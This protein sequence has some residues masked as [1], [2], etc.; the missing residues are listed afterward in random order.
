MLKHKRLYSILVSVGMLI[1]A[2][3]LVYLF[4][5]IYGVSKEN[6]TNIA[7]LEIE[8]NT[9]DLDYI[10]QQ[11]VFEVNMTADMIDNMIKD[12]KSND[13]IEKSLQNESKMTIAAFGKNSSGKDIVNGLYGYIRDKFQDGAG[14]VPDSNFKPTERPW[15]KEAINGNGDAVFVDPYLDEY[16][17][18]ETYIMTISKMLSDNKSVV[19]LD[20]YLTKVEEQVQAIK[21]DKKLDNLV[22]TDSGFVVSSTETEIVGKNIAKTNNLFYNELSKELSIAN[23]KDFEFRYDGT[24]YTVFNKGLYDGWT[25]LVIQET[26]DL[27]S[28]LKYLYI[29]F[30]SIFIVIVLGT[31]LLVYSI[32]RKR[33]R[34]EDINGKLNS[35]A[36]VYISMFKFDFVNKNCERVKEDLYFKDINVK[37]KTPEELFF[38]IKTRLLKNNKNELSTIDLVKEINDIDSTDVHTSEYETNLGWIRERFIVVEKE[39]SKIRSVLWVLENIDSEKKREELLKKEILRDELTRLYNRK[40]YEHKLQSYE[41]GKIEDNLVFVAM[42][43][44][45][46][47]YTNDNYGH[48]AGDE[49]IK[50]AGDCIKECFENYGNIYRTGGDEFIAIIYVEE[51]EITSLIQNFEKVVSEWEGKLAKTLSISYGYATKQEFPNA[52]IIELA[53]IADNRMYDY[54]NEYYVKKGITR[55]RNT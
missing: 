15:Y 11:S 35:I 33:K 16:T 51:N 25:S 2:S 9:K 10:L 43:V 28:S 53:K 27:A 14:W 26:S 7:S 45:G 37:N 55:S 5:R 22:V 40:A 50:G 29:W 49:I 18:T 20:V 39:Q 21:K 17:E 12:N 44:N 1:L 36:N 42:D 52:R 48:L 38:E 54:K 19:A 34:A 6:A 41:K 31:G 3:S 4:V 23:G 8:K 30:G 32:N 24:S 47:K 46:L 13:E